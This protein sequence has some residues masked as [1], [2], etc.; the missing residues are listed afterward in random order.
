MSGNYSDS[1]PSH[2]L[3]VPVAQFHFISLCASAPNRFSSCSIISQTSRFSSAIKKNG[4]IRVK[5][6][7]Y[8]GA[9]T[10]CTIRTTHAQHKKHRSHEH[11]QTCPMCAVSTVYV[12]RLKHCS[13][14]VCDICVCMLVESETTHTR[15][16][17]AHVSRCC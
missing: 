7:I 17:D 10:V 4:S 16:K 15:K 11:T 14:V 3:K 5:I 12:I 13:T 1:K 2:L 9:V 6:F 8:K